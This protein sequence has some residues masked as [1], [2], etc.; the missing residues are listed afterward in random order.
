MQDSSQASLSL[1][2]CDHLF[3][4]RSRSSLSAEQAGTQVTE[5]PH[6]KWACVINAF[7]DRPL[8]SDN[9]KILTHPTNERFNNPKC[10]QFPHAKQNRPLLPANLKIYTP[11]FSLRFSILL[12]FYHT[13]AVLVFWSWSKMR[14]SEEVP[15]AWAHSQMHVSKTRGSITGCSFLIKKFTNL[16]LMEAAPHCFLFLFCG[17]TCL[18]NNFWTPN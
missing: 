7:G 2:H 13:E 6:N 1:R 8:V 4:G 17:L 16:I 11:V 12:P 9:N 14:Q 3:W 15:T 5:A 18:H 10:L